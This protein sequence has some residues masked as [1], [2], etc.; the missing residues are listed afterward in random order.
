MM[1]NKGYSAR[2]HRDDEDGIFIGRVTGIR[3][4]VGF[5]ADN[6]RALRE[7]FREAVDDYLATCAK[8]GKVPQRPCSDLT[9][10]CEK[11]SRLTN[12]KACS[13]KSNLARRESG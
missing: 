6:V 5:H 12:R 11:T 1:K 8:A 4:G 9:E 10:D 2:I 7:A 3:D 13:W